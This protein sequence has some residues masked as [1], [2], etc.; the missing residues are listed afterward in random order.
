M[1]TQIRKTKIGESEKQKPFVESD[2]NLC[3]DKYVGSLC[4]R[5]G[6]KL[7]FKLF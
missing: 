7:L 1:L 3:F 6:K 2:R 5:A 4:R